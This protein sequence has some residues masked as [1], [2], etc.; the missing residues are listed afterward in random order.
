MDDGRMMPHRAEPG[1]KV[2]GETDSRSAT[3]EGVGRWVLIGGLVLVVVVFAI[4][5]GIYF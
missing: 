4:L 1:Q 5:Y 3:T 2:L